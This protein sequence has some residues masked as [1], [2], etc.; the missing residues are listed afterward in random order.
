MLELVT[1]ETF[2]GFLFV[3]F[4]FLQEDKCPSGCRLEGLINVADEDIRKRL[5]NICE[6]IQQ[7]Q[8]FTSSVMQ[9]SVQFY[10]SRRKTIIQ[11][12]SM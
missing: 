3:C 2:L 6:R 4:F 7:N 9:K 1:I 11:T 12:Y 10:G 5:R 8:D